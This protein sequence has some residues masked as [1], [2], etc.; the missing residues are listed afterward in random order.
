MTTNNEKNCAKKEDGKYLTI[1]SPFIM[2]GARCKEDSFVSY[3][4]NDN[5]KKYYIASVVEVDSHPNKTKAYLKL[6]APNSHDVLNELL[7]SM[8]KESK[9]HLLVCHKYIK[10]GK[11]T[12]YS[13]NAFVGRWKLDVEYI[14]EKPS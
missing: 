7:D 14:S 11:E 12:I 4:D 9:I 10:D 5:K 13:P 3:N 1:S 2:V 6:I 8:R